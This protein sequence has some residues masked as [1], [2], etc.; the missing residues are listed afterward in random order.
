MRELSM[1]VFNKGK[2]PAL[3]TQQAFNIKEFSLCRGVSETH[4]N[5]LSQGKNEVRS[6]CW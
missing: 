6:A 1:R 2:L 4:R 3:G 5:Q